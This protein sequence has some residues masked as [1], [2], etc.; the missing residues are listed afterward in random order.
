MNVYSAQRKKLSD[1]KCIFHHAN[2]IAS[3]ACFFVS[4]FV[5]V[6]CLLFTITNVTF[7]YN[8]HNYYKEKMNRL[9][10]LQISD[11]VY[12]NRP[13]MKAALAPVLLDN[14]NF[15]TCFC[16]ILQCGNMVLFLDDDR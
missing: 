6:F 5:C 10:S 7:F 12:L 13:V 1:P 14:N 2:Q 8:H 16:C 11:L 4:F 9:I 15:L 3:N